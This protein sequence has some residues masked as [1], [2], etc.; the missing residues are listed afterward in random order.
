MT[1]VLVKHPVKKNKA[2]PTPIFWYDIE[3][4]KM[5]RFDADRIEFKFEYD[6]E[7]KKHVRRP[8][9]VVVEEKDDTVEVE[10]WYKTYERGTSGSSIESKQNDG[11]R[12]EV[13]DDEVDDFIRSANRKKLK[14][15]VL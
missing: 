12:F 2:S 10:D 6:K 8:F 13:E 4:K 9:G 14:T 11:I 5:L 1:T 15:R 3:N 7:L